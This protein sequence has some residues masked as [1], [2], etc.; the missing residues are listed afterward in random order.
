MVLPG[1][2]AILMGLLNGPVTAEAPPTAPPAGPRAPR[3]PKETEKETEEEK[4]AKRRAKLRRDFDVLSKKLEHLRT[5]ARRT[6][7]EDLEK[8]VDTTTAKVF[9]PDG[10]VNQEQLKEA[11]K[12]LRE[13]LNLPQTEGEKSATQRAIETAVENAKAA[14]DTLVQTKDEVVKGTKSFLSGLAAIPGM[15]VDGGKVIFTTIRDIKH[16]KRGL[17]ERTKAWI[18]EHAAEESAAIGKALN[19]GRV[20]DALGNMIKME[21]KAAGHL[22]SGPWKFVRENIL[23]IDEITCWTDPHASWEECMWSIPSGIA[24]TLSIMM[25]FESGRTALRTPV[26]G[27]ETSSPLIRTAD[28][29]GKAG[30]AAKAKWQ[31]MRA[32]VKPKPPPRIPPPRLAGPLGKLQGAIDDAL[33]T[34]DDAERARKVQ[35]IYRDGGMKQLGKLEEAGGLSQEQ[36]R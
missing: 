27:T 8:W 11:N 30:K 29:I 22:L 1:L 25:G 10:S 32:P 28:K 35:Q 3:E 19:E 21:W 36:I 12:G 18:D 15:I 26:V 7:N 2:I 23:P 20:L 14:K 24:K 6:K 13:A 16:F 4:E 34:A 17:D 31:Q 33:N 9:N 5:I